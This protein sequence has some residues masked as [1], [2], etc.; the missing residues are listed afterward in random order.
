MGV[1]TLKYQALVS[2][3]HRRHLGQDREDWRM[4][5]LQTALLAALIL[6][7]M[8]LQATEAGEAGERAGSPQKPGLHP[9]ASASCSG[10]HTGARA[11]IPVCHWLM[12]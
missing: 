2:S 10:K 8:V 6:L 5:S 9:G 12:G 11:D 1:A 4:A 3:G 7:A